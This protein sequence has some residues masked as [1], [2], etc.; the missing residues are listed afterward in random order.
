MWK[1]NLFITEGKNTKNLE[2]LEYL[3]NLETFEIIGYGNK[4]KTLSH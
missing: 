3:V 1:N 2:G 4:I